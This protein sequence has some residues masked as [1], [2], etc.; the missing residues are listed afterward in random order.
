MLLGLFAI[1]PALSVAILIVVMV[2]V[3]S[4]TFPIGRLMI[5]CILASLVLYATAVVY[6]LYAIETSAGLTGEEKKRWSFVLVMWFPVAAP[7]FWYR[8]VWRQQLASGGAD[9]DKA[10]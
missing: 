8:Y 10:E 1:A 2:G 5:V 4:A 9:K 3:R 7:A 6:F